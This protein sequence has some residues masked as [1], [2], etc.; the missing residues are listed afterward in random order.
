MTA[1]ISSHTSA[2]I[3]AERKE[4]S[5]SWITP[6]RYEPGFQGILVSDLINSQQ[7]YSRLEG[8][9]SK[10]VSGS[11]YN[12]RTTKDPGCL[13]AESYW[14]N[15]VLPVCDAVVSIDCVTSIS[16]TGP[17]LKKH[18][19]TFVNYVYPN[20]PN[21]FLPDEKLKI[22]QPAQPSVWNIPSVPHPGG[23]LY[24]LIAGLTGSTSGNAPRAAENFYAHLLP[25]QRVVTGWPV[26]NKVSPDGFFAYFPQCVT[27]SPGVRGEA[28]VGCM[29]MRDQGIGEE[30]YRCA[31]WVDE[32]S[33]CY[34]QRPFPKDHTFTLDFRLTSSI[35]GWLHGRMGEPVIGIQAGD[36]G[37]TE[38]SITAK[39][40]EVPIYYAGELY[41]DL[42]VP[43]KDLYAKS[44]H[45][46]RGAGYG[47]ICCEVE[48]DP[49]KRNSTSTPHPFGDDSIEELAH[50]LKNYS[51]KAVA[52]P[53]MWSVRSMASWELSR[54]NS[55]FTVGKDL[56]GIVTTNSATYSDGPPRF[57][58]GSLNYRVASPHLRQD[59]ETFKGTYD[60]VVRSDVARCLYG[61]SSAPVSAEIEVVSDSGVESIATSVLGERDGWLFLSVKNFTF[62]APTIKA[63]FVQ[64]ESKPDDAGNQSLQ[65]QVEA[66]TMAKEKK[67]SLVCVKG[68]KTKKLSPM[69][70]KCPRGFKKQKVARRLGI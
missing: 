68:N 50:W 28:R 47:R 55:C 5:E 37:A 12:C 3:S 30:Q 20:H 39:P 48:T 21:R 41:K 2:S 44:G 69:S 40:I 8:F 54:A 19:A 61:Y 56:K 6:D 11:S 49:I 52:T 36:D 1:L 45:L 65:N 46:S 27:K 23:T 67:I 60:L 31:L 13:D 32:G 58:D 4:E 14:F 35:S 16:A 18:Q 66:S 26:S 22:P 7:L 29:G 34:I 63:R 33:D 64:Q 51:D 38:L 25:V 62:S 17:D 53:S 9:S 42:P 15:A 59:G 43:L 10:P 24:A 57:A 70:S